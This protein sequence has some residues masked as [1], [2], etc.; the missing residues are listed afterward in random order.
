MKLRHKL[1]LVYGVVLVISVLFCSFQLLDRA[2]DSQL[3]LTAEQLSGNLYALAD[4]LKVRVIKDL[5]VNDSEAVVNSLTAWH[6]KNLKMQG[7]AL[8]VNGRYLCNLSPIAPEK[9]L[10]PEINGDQSSFIGKV[11][12]NNYLIVSMNIKIAP[13]SDGCNLYAVKD[14]SSLYES[15]DRLMWKFISI[16]IIAGVFGF[17]AIIAYTGYSLKPLAELNTAACRIAA[18]EY[19]ERVQVKSLDEVGELGRSF[20]SMAQCI[21]ER[22]EELKE[23]AE[24]QKLFSGAVSH[25]FKTPLTAIALTADSLQN[26]CMSEEEQYE[27]LALIE[28]ECIWLEK[29]TQKLLKLV[30]L[31]GEAEL[32]PC[33]AKELFDGVME[34][35]GKRAEELGIEI[36]A[37]NG[38][39]IF[40]ADKTL[41]LSAILNLVD[42]AMKASSCGDKIYIR[43]NKN[44]IEVEDNGK[45]MNGEELKHIT[46]PFYMA[47]KS[48]S[49]AKGGVGLGLSL[50]KEICD[51]HGAELVFSSKV[52]EGTKAKIIFR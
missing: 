24:R 13:E 40:N 30:A 48:R 45:G 36:V 5:N 1:P 51:I 2:R 21:E 23:A 19:R 29:L 27:A 37:E 15:L 38:N 20:N 43:A 11:G 25:E 16:G 14:L 22:I 18:G 44:S 47:D 9:Y 42:N 12:D 4:E 41:M 50:T 7:T 33:P 10:K 3:E 35:L 39:E 34:T 46:E 26:T 49:K 31:K 52:G 28:K 8:S 32:T 17:F 6:F